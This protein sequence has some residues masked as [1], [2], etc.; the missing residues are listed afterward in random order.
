MKKLLYNPEADDK[1]KSIIKGDTSNVFD[2]YNIKYKWA[3]KIWESMLA[4][5]WVPEKSTMVEDKSSFKKLSESEKEAYQKILSFLIF[6]DSLQTSNV[7]N[8]SNHITASEIV[9]ALARQTFD[10]AIHSRS[11][12]H[13]MTSIFTEEEANKAIYYWREDEVLRDRNE[14]IANIY[15][16]FDDQYSDDGLIE[17]LVANYLLEGLYFYNGFQF[18]FNLESRHLMT[19]TAVQIRYIKKDELNHCALFKEIIKGVSKEEPKL[20]NRNIEHIYDMF[21]KAVEQEIS[22]SNHAIGDNILGMSKQSIEDYTYYMANKRLKDIGL[23][24]IFDKRENPY[25]HLDS[26]SGAEDES[27]VK[28]NMFETQSTAYKQASIIDGWDDL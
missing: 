13:I 5:H 21:R 3:Y 23:E 14:Y 11:Y 2:L 20:W 19:N 18:F 10:E 27:S 15:Q 7:P 6:L 12:G 16:K 25:K 22:F 9:L 1:E 8:I 24:Q 26:I 4:N 17:V 28:A